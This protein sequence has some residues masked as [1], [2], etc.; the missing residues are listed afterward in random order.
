[1]D[2]VTESRL[3]PPAI[4][5]PG[6]HREHRRSVRLFSIALRNLRRRPE[7]TL[8]AVLGIGLTITVAIV[9]ESISTGYQV[10]GAAAYDRADAGAPIWILP[11]GGFT[12]SPRYDTLLPNGVLPQPAQLGSGWKVRQTLGAV[13]K[14]NGRPVPVLGSTGNPLGVATVSVPAAR[15][16]H[17]KPGSTVT[18]DGSSLRVRSGGTQGAYVEVPLATARALTGGRG[19]LT[20]VPP[21]ADLNVRSQLA[22]STHSPVTTD[23]TQAATHQHG[24]VYITQGGGGVFTFRDRFSALLGGRVQGSVLGLVAKLALFLGFVISVTSF[25]AAVQERRREFGVLAS[26]GLTDEVLY[27]FLAEA[28]LIFASAYVF[29]L[30]LAVVLLA[31]ASPGQLSASDVLQA[32]ALVLTY[33]PA[34]GI[35]AALIP[36]H[37]I[38]Q[39]RPVDLL[40]EASS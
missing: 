35:F 17:L 20:A 37:R 40:R 22:A 18:V 8:L 29:G 33:L 34:L 7:H 16:L 11:A 25:L 9:V 10:R 1:M 14:V 5:P 24:I 3:E 19:W 12:Y 38:T 4:D 26:I 21:A 27:F 32:A 2:V 36:A 23:P 30:G 6:H 28:G 15:L 31:G 39:Q 13:T